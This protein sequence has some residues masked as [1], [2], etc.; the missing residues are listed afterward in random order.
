MCLRMMHMLCKLYIR[1]YFL[2]TPSEG[3]MLLKT[4]LFVQKNSERDLLTRTSLHLWEEA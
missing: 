1:V 4:F 3:V 2:V